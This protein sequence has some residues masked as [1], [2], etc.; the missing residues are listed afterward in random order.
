MDENNEIVQLQ[1]QLDSIRKAQSGSDR[2][3]TLLQQENEEL[4]K[5]IAGE[6][7]Q[8][9]QKEKLLDR[10]ETALKLALEKGI[11]PEKAFQLLGLDNDPDDGDRLDLYKTS[12]EDAKQDAADEYAKRNG[13]KDIRTG[14]GLGNGEVSY[15]ELSKMPDKQL[16]QLSPG[17][18]NRAI[19]AEMKSTRLTVRQRIL[20]RT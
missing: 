1:E 14:Y 11:A 8:L 9:S 6:G 3:V 7:N 17:V 18:L 10:K 19:D 12:L 15:S 13:R 20:G 16:Q 2:T 4:K 5:Q